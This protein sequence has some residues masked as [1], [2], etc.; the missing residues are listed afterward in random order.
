MSIIK[1]K[2]TLTQNKIVII[3][4]IDIQYHVDIQ[5]YADI[6]ICNYLSHIVTI[7]ISVINL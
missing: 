6:I 4:L 5:Y 1:P 2:L 7:I 3:I